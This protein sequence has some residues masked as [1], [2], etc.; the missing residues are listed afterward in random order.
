[1]NK[2]HVFATL[3]AVSYLFWHFLAITPVY[4]ANEGQIAIDEVN[5]TITPSDATNYDDQIMPL[6]DDYDQIDAYDTTAIIECSGNAFSTVCSNDYQCENSQNGEENCQY[7]PFSEIEYD[8]GEPDEKG[9]R[10]CCKRTAEEIANI[11]HNG[12]SGEAEVICADE[13]EPD[14]TPENEAETEPELWPLI[15]SLS[16]LGFTIVF[17]II[18]N[19]IGRRK[20]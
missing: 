2:K 5:N 3:L 9:M 6:T 14:C 1:M 16:A 12:T 20:K 19:L 13:N 15:L 8:C 17:V 18:I 7:V 10:I 4:A 11:E